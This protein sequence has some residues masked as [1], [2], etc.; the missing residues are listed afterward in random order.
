[1][2]I[3]IVVLLSSLSRVCV[4]RIRRRH[5]ISKIMPVG[6]GRSPELEAC[7]YRRR[8]R[9]EKQRR[10]AEP[11]LACGVVGHFAVMEPIC[12]SWCSFSP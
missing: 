7:A 8:S 4:P 6:I 11:F 10:L 5:P 12:D 2:A 1:M 3:S 9:L